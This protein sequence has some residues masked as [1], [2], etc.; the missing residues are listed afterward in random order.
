MV[1]SILI[2]IL[3]FGLGI[4]FGLML[5]RLGV[6]IPGDSINIAFVSLMLAVGVFCGSCVLSRYL[7][8]SIVFYVGTFMCGVLSLLPIWILV[9]LYLLWWNPAKYKEY[10]MKKL[11]RQ[12][13]LELE[14]NEGQTT[15]DK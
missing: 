3:I 1:A 7:E 9:G 10:E 14:R 12:R 13:Q 6:T 15:E 2:T 11:R 4:A 5:M 8:N